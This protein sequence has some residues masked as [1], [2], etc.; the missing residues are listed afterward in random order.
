[1]M[2]TEYSVQCSAVSYDVFSEQCAVQ[3]LI[4]CTFFSVQYHTCLAPF[5]LNTEMGQQKQ[6]VKMPS[7]LF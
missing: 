2:L 7:V 4:T 5:Y 1:M 6:P 3:C